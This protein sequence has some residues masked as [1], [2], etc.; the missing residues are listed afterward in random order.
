[1]KQLH[2]GTKEYVEGN[3]ELYLTVQYL[4]HGPGKKAAE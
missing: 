2:L 4:L 3:G 1:M